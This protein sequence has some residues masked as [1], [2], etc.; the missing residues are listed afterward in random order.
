MMDA[1]IALVHPKGRHF[2]AP[3]K[4]RDGLFASSLPGIVFRDRRNE[5]A[6]LPANGEGGLFILLAAGDGRVS[7]GAPTICQAPC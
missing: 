3:S 4:W 1:W 2:S 5:E 6:T 7:D